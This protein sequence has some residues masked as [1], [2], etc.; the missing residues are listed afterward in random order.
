MRYYIKVGLSVKI[1]SGWFLP[2]AVDFQIG[3][4]LADE[5]TG[6]FGNTCK[7]LQKIGEDMRGDLTQLLPSGLLRG[8]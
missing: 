4:V 3:A 6:I 8:H 5:T 1:E 2:D 7:S